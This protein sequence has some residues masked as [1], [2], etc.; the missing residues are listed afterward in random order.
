MVGSMSTY[1]M[2]DVARRTADLVRE[3][4]YGREPVMITDHGRPAAVLISPEAMERYKALEDAADLAEIEAIKARG[5]VW[6]GNDDAQ[7]MMDQWLEEA[8][9]ADETR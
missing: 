6:I 3:A 7:R 4:R 1:T 8:E 5:P 2:T 9:A